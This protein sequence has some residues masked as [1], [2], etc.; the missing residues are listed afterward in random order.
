MGKKIIGGIIA[1]CSH[2]ITLVR[3]LREVYGILGSGN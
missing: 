3:I 1:I 2:S